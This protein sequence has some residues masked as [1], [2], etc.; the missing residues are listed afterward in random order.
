MSEIRTC[1]QVVYLRSD[2]RAPEQGR[3]KTSNRKWGEANLSCITE[4]ITTMCYRDS[5]LLD[6]L[7]AAGS[8]PRGMFIPR[9]FRV[10]SQTST[11]RLDPCRNSKKVHRPNSNLCVEASSHQ[12][13]APQMPAGCLSHQLNSG[14]IYREREPATNWRSWRPPPTPPTQEAKHNPK[15]LPVL[16]T[17]WLQIRGSHDS[18]TGFD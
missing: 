16:P 3:W 4:Q 8:C 18:L 2:P 5:T 1:V 17:N 14:T 6:V 15:L 9:Y 12:Q 10:C 7:W 13:A 11:G